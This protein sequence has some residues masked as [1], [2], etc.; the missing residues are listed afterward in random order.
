LRA[1]EQIAGGGSKI[2][3]TRPPMKRPI[4]KTKLATTIFVIGAV[5][6]PLGAY[7][8]D[9]ATDHPAKPM[10]A[11]KD[12]VITTKVKAKLA[13]E[14]MSTLGNISVETDNKG[15]VALS[16]YTKSQQEADKAIEIARA[17]EGVSSVT[18][19]I[20]IKPQ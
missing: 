20:Q 4:M 19:K 13:A 9:A 12:S 11:V 6:A 15:A 1:S 5:L 8:A 14:K 2:M 18:S 16:G 3:P 7:A 17:T 10:T